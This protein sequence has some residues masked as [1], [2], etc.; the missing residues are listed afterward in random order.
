MRRI[1]VGPARFVA[2]VADVYRHI[3]LRNGKERRLERKRKA[4]AL[5][6]IGQ[7]GDETD[8]GEADPVLLP[9][10]P[11]PMRWRHLCLAADAAY[12]GE[13]SRA[14]NLP[15]TAEAMQLLWERVFW[16]VNYAW[17]GAA[18]SGYAAPP[19]EAIGQW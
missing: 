7:D 9:A 13:A 8:G 17:S 3:L 11:A 1:C 4:S 12:T 19:V 14:R 16:A 15:P 5:G 2:F 6:D 10:A 18:G